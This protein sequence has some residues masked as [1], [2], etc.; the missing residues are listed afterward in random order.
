[1]PRPWSHSRLG[2]TDSEQPALVGDVPACCGGLEQMALHGPFQ[3]KPFH[4]SKG[5]FGFQE[6][7]ELPRFEEGFLYGETLQKICFS[8]KTIIRDPGVH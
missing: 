8:Y 3:P 6:T 5:H 1:M 7:T 2:W 4:E